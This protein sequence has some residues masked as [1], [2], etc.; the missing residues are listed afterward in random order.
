MEGRKGTV[1]YV[2]TSTVRALSLRSSPLI[3][4]YALSQ[5]LPTARS[6]TFLGLRRRSYRSLGSPFSSVNAIGLAQLMKRRSMMSDEDFTATIDELT[7]FVHGERA[8]PSGRGGEHRFPASR[9]PRK[10]GSIVPS[11]RMHVDVMF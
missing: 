10:N 2:I 4:L 5:I 6:S 9:I 3:T 11:M 1:E 8:S 7:L